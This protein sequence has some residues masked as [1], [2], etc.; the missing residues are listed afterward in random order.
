MI[1]KLQDDFYIAINAFYNE[2]YQFIS[3]AKSKTFQQ[4]MKYGNIMKRVHLMKMQNQESLR[5]I[6][7]HLHKSI[8]NLKELIYLM[9][10]QFI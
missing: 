9:A 2:K 6:Q 5:A 4:L 10:F 7:F 1:H 3:V 8:I